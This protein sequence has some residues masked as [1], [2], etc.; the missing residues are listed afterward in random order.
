M[1]NA[2]KKLQF[3]LQAAQRALAEVEAR[4]ERHDAEQ[5]AATKKLEENRSTLPFML[6]DLE[7]TRKNIEQAHQEWMASLDVVNDPIFLHDKQF[8]ILH[9][10]K[11]YQQCAGMPFDELAGR[12]YYEVFP[13]AAGPLRSCLMAMEEGGGE[14][15]IAVDG[16]VYR[17]R[18]FSV[19]DEQGDYRHSMHIL[20][21]IT[22]HKQTE[23]AFHTLIGTAVANVG[24]E[25]FREAVRSLSTWLGMECVIV[26]E[27]EDENSMRA[28]AMQLDG[29]MAEHYECALPDAS[30][31]SVA[32][33]GYCEYAEGVC[34]LF[35][36][37]KYLSDMGAEAYVGTPI[38]DNNG[39]VNG[40]LCAIS[41]HKIVLPPMTRGVFEII[42]A[43]AG[44]EIERK[45]AEDALRISALKHR[46]LFESSR[47]ALLLLA[48]PSWQFTGANQATLQLF[49]AS[50]VAEFTALGP[51][52]VVP[53]RQPDGRLSSEKFPEMIATAMRE[54]AHFFKWEH[55]RLDGRQFTADVLLTRMDVEGEVFLQATVRDITERTQAE[56]ELRKLS[57][58]V[59]QSPNT[60]I[61]TDRDSNI[62]YVNDAYIK[63]SGYSRSEVIGQN[64]R[65]LRS[66]RTARET[67]DDMWAHLARGE[68]W[69]GEI[70]NRRKDGSEY[71]ESGFVSPIR[72][73][74]GRITH[75][76]G[77]KHDITEHKR[78]EAQVLAQYQQ[79]AAIN[80]QLVE[81][82]KQ[83]KQAQNQLLQ[84][85]KMAAIGLL[86]AGV[87]H[88]I[89]NPVG[90]VNSNLGTL[91]KYLADIF[92]VMDKFEAAEA[93]MGVDNPLLE[94]L[95]Q[96]KAKIDLAYIREDTKALIAESHQGLER[97]KGIILDLK[98][99]SH[100]DSDDQWVWA[101]VHQGLDSTLNVVWNEL[102]YKCEIVREYGTLPNIYCLPSQLSQVFMDLLINAAQAIEVRG[103]IT[104][105]SGQ[106]GDR[107]WVEV[108]DTGQ[109]IPPENF[110]RLFDPFFTTKPVG[111]GTGLGLSVS[112][113]IIEKHHG[114]IE[115]QSEVGKG[116]TFRVWLPVQQPVT[117][118][119]K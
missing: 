94:E 18:S 117:K 90:Y 5:Q 40:I 6:A 95:R 119:K 22:E 84:S 20:E 46:L 76:L 62:E 41:R 10:N 79:V 25:F 83:L 106:E 82:N 54:G 109:G 11:V 87:A 71:I 102:K 4:Y 77:I 69:K 103:K 98:E 21:N 115:V 39:K 37:D 44:T 72:G 67:Y 28:L 91:E 2:T 43:R 80:A 111:I 61:I 88:E 9:C 110:S 85:E 68:V 65:I 101:D 52:D 24:A 60:I 13:K 14:E 33:K 27:M 57:Q 116:S 3:E 49:G 97:V 12:P 100:A 93:L 78:I 58:A 45:R 35:P 108:T 75:Y 112:Y 86:A 66:G 92:I 96:F 29:Q 50:S 19:H 38:R 99:F 17:S 42:A 8:R 47:D 36:S 48:P 32:L 7:N 74:D 113:T 23:A 16:T 30:F 59:E 56:D 31:N 26:A 34:R 81:T 118:E 105:R 104:L 15:E 73:A 64:P 107:I 114:K 53:E 55:Q 1:S 89:N 63:A 51:T 70:I